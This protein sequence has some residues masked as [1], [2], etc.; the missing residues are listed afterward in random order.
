MDSKAL[1]AK[2]LTLM[3]GGVNSPLRA[4]RYVNAE[5]VFIDRA[6]GAR[7]WDVEG[8]EYID[9]V[10]SWGPMILGHQDPAVTEAAHRAVDKGSSYGAPCLGE[11]TL[12]EEISRLVPSMEMMRMVSSGTE[13]TMSALR[14]ARGF[15]GRSKFVKF[16]GNYHGHADSFLAAAG[17]AAATVPGTPGVPEEIVRHT[18]LAHYNDLDAVR[19]HFAAS[20]SE[21][22][23][24]I[25]EPAA[26]NMGLV[27][28]ADGFLEGLRD[29][30]TEHGALLIFDEVITGFRLAPGGAQE[31]FGIKPDLTTL[32]KII[33][34]GFPVG[35]YGGSR[36][37]MEHMAPVGGVFQAGTLSGNP[38]AMAAGLATLKR[39]GECDYPALEART[40]AFARELAA[41]MESKGQAVTLNAI[42]SAFTMY[43]SQ[44][45][46]TNMIESGKCD[47]K[48]YATFWQQMLAQGIYLAPAGFE[49]AFTSFAHTDEDFATTLDAARKVRF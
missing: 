36:T 47:S 14:L 29:L 7:M 4:C 45:P 1:Y 18:L 44:G 16:I 9:Y 5:P 27:L 28:P 42:A 25:V 8:R 12:A 11:I 30:C 33:G 39:L 35:C 23:C 48:A 20:G 49:C 15:T 22:A 32:G 31:R 21:I 34:G 46:V 19:A 26:G 24:V 3:P 43:F 38:V 37:I 17:S 13:A 40:L 10:L 41:I 6:K 2:A